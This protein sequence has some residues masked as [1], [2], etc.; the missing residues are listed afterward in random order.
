MS[1]SNYDATKFFTENLL[2]IEMKKTQI[3]MNKPLYL[4]LSILELSK[5]SMCEI[6]YDYVKQKYGD[7]AKLCYVLYGYRHCTHKN[8]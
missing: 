3:Y 6:W 7:K 5:I 8:K 2:A 1:E 4:G